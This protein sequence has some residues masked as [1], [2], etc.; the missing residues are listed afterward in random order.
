MTTR[1]A[2]VAEAMTWLRTPYHH[3]ARV[4]GAGVDCAQILIGVFAGV[5]LIAAFDAGDYPRDWM[6][7]RDED[8]FR[9]CVRQH[10]DQ[11]DLADLQPGDVALYLVGKCFAHGAIALDWP[12]ILHADSRYG[13]VTLADGD[14]GWLAGRPVEFYR[15][16]GL[17]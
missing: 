15:I 10:A 1:A 9:A 2:I 12:L 3:R 11:I 16:R 13:E 5:G 6:L 4:K 8:R 17:A 7:H 14:Q